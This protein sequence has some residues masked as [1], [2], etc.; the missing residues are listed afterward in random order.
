MCSMAWDQHEFRRK[1]RTLDHA[2][3]TGHASRI[4][5]GSGHNPH[6]RPEDL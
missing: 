5:P 4:L 1:L 3:K 2:A 6:S